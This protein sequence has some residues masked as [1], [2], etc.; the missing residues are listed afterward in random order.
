MELAYLT[1]C[2]PATPFY[3]VA[4]AGA[5]DF[6]IDDR[7]LPAGWSMHRDADW[8]YCAPPQ[9]SLPDQGWKIH[10]SATPENASHVLDV[11]R[12]YC[13]V[14]GSCSSSCAG[15]RWCCAATASTG[16][17]AAAASS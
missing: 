13:T 6:P 1:Y 15:R 7:P 8:T 10:V 9:L 11:T 4:A 14:R 5:D 12:D 16:I 3:D 17:G 2:L